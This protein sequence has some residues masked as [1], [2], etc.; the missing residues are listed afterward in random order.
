MF[1][2]DYL[3]QMSNQS[4]PRCL[5]LRHVNL[6]DQ[7]DD[8]EELRVFMTITNKLV[9]NLNNNQMRIELDYK[10]AWQE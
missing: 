6:L 10:K 1:I 2:T 7:V 4:L 3:H 8:V 5:R 9:V